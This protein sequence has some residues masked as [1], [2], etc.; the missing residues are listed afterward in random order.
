MKQKRQN[1]SEILKLLNHGVAFLLREQQKDG[2]FLSYSTANKRNF[3]NAK[4]YHS[5][6][7]PALI[8][9]SLSALN[10]TAALNDIKGKLAKLLLGQKSEH[11]SFN[12]WV[13]GSDEAKVMPYPD[14][15]DDTFC[16]LS[17]LYLYN[18]ELTAPEVLAKVVMLLTY[19]EEKEGG[20]YRTWFVPA[21]AEP[22]WKDIDLAVNSNIAYFLS[23]QDV[24]LDNIIKL[25][26]E[27]IDK[28]DYVS[29]YYPSFYPVIYFISRFYSGEK[30]DK[31]INFLLSKKDNNWKWQ[32][33]LNTALVVSSLLNLEYSPPELEKSINY[34]I[35]S[36]KNGAWKPYAFCLDPAIKGK[37]YYAGSSA[38]TTAFCLEALSKYSKGTKDHQKTKTRKAAADY[39][40]KKMYYA[41]I[42]ETQGQIQKLSGTLK[43]DALRAL[44]QNLK[45]DKDRQIV[46]MPYFFKCS[47]G[48]RGKEISDSFIVNLGLA[49]LY[50]WMAYTI[51]DDFLDN[52]GDPKLLPAANVFLRELT[53]IFNDLLPEE[54]GFRDFFRELMDKLESANNWE[55]N[56]CRM[57]TAKSRSKNIRIP[58]YDTA[59]RLSDRSLGHALGPAAILFS[60]GYDSRSPEIRDLMEFFSNYL[61]ARQLDD[62]AHDW[63]EDL[64]A[65]RINAA[66]SCLLRKA[67]EKD[68]FTPGRTSYKEG[69]EIDYLREL[70]WYEVMPLVCENMLLFLKRAE[71]ALERIEIISD[72]FVLK[73]LLERIERSAQKSIKERGETVS[74]LRTYKDTQ[75]T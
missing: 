57:K 11:W 74:F 49:N 1:K 62:E 40:A 15:L 19:V 39:D 43:K 41:I 66:V 69:N 12:Y 52:E 65:G 2:S 35:K 18:P 23:L 56:Y 33:P 46:L 38:L 64:K 73:N 24:T 42:K 55:V 71:E 58:I 17:A 54:I 32:N 68:I 53:T 29:P 25:V 10:E 22:V 20:P 37:K 30:K 31:V 27:K 44:N 5:V 7:I 26:E 70:F 67:K 14:D 63:E 51:Y 36:Q 16:A 21:S 3:K 61:A 60:L 45:S 13:R 75:L 59:A 28:N 6:F 8:L 72:K 34:L 47:L 48:K 9:S 50:G 4:T